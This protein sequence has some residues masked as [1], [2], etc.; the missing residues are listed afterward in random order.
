[1]FL[2]T[3]KVTDEL[4]TTEDWALILEICDR[5]QSHPTGSVFS[6]H[7][8]NLLDSYAV[9]LTRSFLVI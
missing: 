7:S 6:K 1:M 4:N 2:F 5:V 8:I 3:E 9:I